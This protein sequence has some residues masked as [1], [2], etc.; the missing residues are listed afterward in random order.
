MVETTQTY[1]QGKGGRQVNDKP[2]PDTWHKMSHREKRHDYTRPYFVKETPPEY[3]GM[4][5][6]CLDIWYEKL[7]RNKLKHRYYDG[8]NKLI[9]LGI[10]TPPELLDL[11]AVVGWP[12]KAVDALAVRSRI[13]GYTAGTDELQ[14]E[15]DAL[16]ERSRLSVMY[17][18]A[19]TSMLIYSCI[20]VTVGLD[21]KG[22]AH[23]ELHSAETAS[24]VWDEAKGRIAYGLVI[25]DWDKDGIPTE[26]VLHTDEAA[27]H[28]YRG[29]YV[30]YFEE[31][32]HSMGR[33]VMEAMTYR[34]TYRK[35]FGQSRV[36][37]SVMSLTDSAVR[38]A[39]GGDISFQ[40]AVAPQK[41]LLSADPEALN[42]QTKW[43]AYIGNIFAVSHNNQDDVQPKFGQLPQASMQQ[44]SDYMRSLAARFSAETNVPLAQLGVNSDANPSSA[45]AIYAANEPLIIECQDLNEG[46]RDTLKSITQMCVAAQHNKSLESLTDE[47]KDFTVNFANPAMP[48]IVSQADAM[49]KIASVVPDFAGTD[50]FF[51]QIGFT[52]DM[53]KKAVSDINRNRGAYLLANALAVESNGD[54]DGQDDTNQD[55]AATALKGSQMNA[56]LTTVQSFV[57]GK[58]TEQQAIN[59]ISAMT[60]LTKQRARELIMGEINVQDAANEMDELKDIS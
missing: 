2:Q 60:G 25:V 59:T 47:E 23:I 9:D 38:C 7:F 36:S 22:E 10:S 50:L 44:Y 40:F 16:A 27:V 15:L 24:A 8:K 39:V 37:R 49:V 29:E 6:E 58:L 1:P 28:F 21:E 54:A 5:Y 19:V 3:I 43:E 56:I 55:I 51:E 34:P 35:P 18:Q 57:A 45:E 14:T 46:A 17:R 30:W 12:Q 20:F 11:N 31:E 32:F 41:Y 52:E 4:V 33:P 53:R 13:D 42:G 26:M 48:S